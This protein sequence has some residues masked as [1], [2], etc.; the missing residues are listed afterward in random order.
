MSSYTWVL[1]LVRIF[2]KSIVL[3]S[4]SDSNSSCV[5]GSLDNFAPRSGANVYGWVAQNHRIRLNLRCRVGVTHI[6]DAGFEVKRGRCR[7]DG[8]VL[9]VNGEGRLGN[10]SGIRQHANDQKAGMKC[11]IRDLLV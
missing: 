11:F 9:V 1:S 7:H 5:T 8:E 4:N 10:G 6:V 3:P 2:W